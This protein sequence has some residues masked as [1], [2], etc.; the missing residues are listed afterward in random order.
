MRHIYADFN[1]VASDGVLPLTCAG[2]LT[3]IANLTAPLQDGEVVLLS[4]GEL[5]V[6]A[7]VHQ[8][9]DGKFEA[10]SDWRFSDRRP[11]DL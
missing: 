5:W 1:D 2:S 6:L 7:T 4:D 8:R 9:P 3:S 11:S 10:T